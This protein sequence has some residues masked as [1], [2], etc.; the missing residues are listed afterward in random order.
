MG[1]LAIGVLGERDIDTQQ[2]TKTLGNRRERQFRNN[3]ALRTAEMRHEDDLGAVGAQSLDGRQG[4]TDTAV[5][6]D[7][8][9]VQRNVEIRADENA[10]ALE[11]SKILQCLHEYPFLTACHTG[12]AG[13]W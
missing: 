9:A 6:G 12:H 2:L 4:G 10:L 11:I 8:G 7:R 13:R 5:I 3:L 1:V